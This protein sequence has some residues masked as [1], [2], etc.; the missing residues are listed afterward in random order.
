MTFA[1]LRALH[2]IIGDSLDEIERV[3]AEAS[4]AINTAGSPSPTP[5]SS[6]A[7]PSSPAFDVTTRP[8]GRFLEFPFSS[9]A[10]SKSNDYGTYGLGESYVS[11]PPSPSVSTFAYSQ[12]APPLYPTT[13]PQTQTQPKL[14]LQP[15]ANVNINRDGSA[16][17]PSPLTPTTP[18]TPYSGSSETIV[19]D[20]P[21]LDVPTYD[22]PPAVPSTSE[23]LTTHPTVIAGKHAS[24]HVFNLTRFRHF[25]LPK[26]TF[27]HQPYSSCC[28]SDERHSSGAILELMRREYGSQCSSP[29]NYLY[30]SNTDDADGYP[31]IILVPPAIL[32]PTPRICSHRRDPSRGRTIRSSR[33]NYRETMRYSRRKTRYPN[34]HISILPQT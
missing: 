25:H 34:H 9:P 6:P 26:I 24:I 17:L 31:D 10:N 30:C 11:P 8:V 1:N 32:P 20:F 13:P 2:G 29:F 4:A 18:S 22:S 27:S 16:T 3:Y 12:S 7:T 28:R 15:S 33:R 14:K 21:S 23:A 5:S 19:L